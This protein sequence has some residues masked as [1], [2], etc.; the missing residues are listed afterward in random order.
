MF[1]ATSRFPLPVILPEAFKS[2]CKVVIPAIFAVP[3]ISIFPEPNI[4][5][6]ELIFPLAV[7]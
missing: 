7:I 5:Q 4:F 6:L 3:S 2:D 1:P